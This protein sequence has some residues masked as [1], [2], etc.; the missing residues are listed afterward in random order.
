MNSRRGADSEIAFVED[1][2]RIDVDRVDL[3][4]RAWLLAAA[5]SRRP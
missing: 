2:R 1:E 5:V 4:R 3:G